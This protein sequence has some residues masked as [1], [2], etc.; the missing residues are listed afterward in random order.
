[1]FY[2]A[3]EKLD[4]G[5]FRLVFLEFDICEYQ[6]TAFL[7]LLSRSFPHEIIC[8]QWVHCTNTWSGLQK[9][10]L[11]NWDQI[12]PVFQQTNIDNCI[13][14]SLFDWRVNQTEGDLL[15]KMPIAES[16]SVTLQ[17]FFYLLLFLMSLWW[18]ILNFAFFAAETVSLLFTLTVTQ[19]PQNKELSGNILISLCVF[20]SCHCFLPV[21][22][23]SQDEVLKWC[24]KNMSFTD[25][26]AI[27][28]SLC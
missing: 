6:S 1:M 21:T 17:E 26:I 9:S 2:L 13:Q 28:M 16:E 25:F 19:L 12:K 15:S 20:F 3:M 27:F 10:H 14:C 18:L 7:Y 23:H 5:C 4:S 11:C 22:W 24:L 8:M